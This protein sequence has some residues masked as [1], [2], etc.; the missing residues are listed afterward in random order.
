MADVDKANFDNSNLT[1]VIVKVNLPRMKAQVVVKAGLLKPWYGYHKLS[2]VIGPGNKISLLGLTDTFTNWKT[3]KVISELEALTE[4]SFVGGQ[5][6]GTVICS[7][8]DA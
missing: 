3:M 7:C 2:R 1:G 6:K 8:R 5:G 4:E